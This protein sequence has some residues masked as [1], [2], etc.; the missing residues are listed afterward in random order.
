[1][2]E[3]SS[4]QMNLESIRRYSNACVTQH[5]FHTELQLYAI[6]HDRPAVLQ[7]LHQQEYNLDSFCDSVAF[8]SLMF[9]AALWNRLRTVET[10]DQL[11]YDVHSMRCDK[12][13]ATP[14]AH[15]RRV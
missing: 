3:I 6:K 10:L 15:A 5:S 13:N 8:G 11:G 4:S 9:Y 1:M 2:R 14:F 12:Y 7:W